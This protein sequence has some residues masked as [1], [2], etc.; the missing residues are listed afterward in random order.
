MQKLWVVTA[1]IVVERGDLLSGNTNAF[2]NAVTWADSS[3][4]AEQKLRE[5][6]ESYEW[7]L[8]GIEDAHPFDDARGYG[9]KVLDAVE[10]AR[11]LPQ[12]CIIIEAFSY[13]P[14]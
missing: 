3:G 1:E 8:V 5:C 13:K 10:R 6:L 12:A 7:S 14:E 11:G 2:V 9:D 4:Q